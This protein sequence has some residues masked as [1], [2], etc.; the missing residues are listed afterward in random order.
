VKRALLCVSAAFLIAGCSGDDHCDDCGG[1]KPPPPPPLERD[2]PQHTVEYYRLAWQDRDSTRID[3]ALTADYQGTSTDIGVISE[4]I[5]FIKSDEIRA[6]HAMKNDDTLRS[7]S[8]DFGPSSSWTRTSY[9]GDPPDWSVVVVPSSA[10]TLMYANGDVITVSPSN[11]QNLF[12]LKP[13]TVVGT[14]TTWQVIRWQ[15]IHN[16]Q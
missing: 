11:D 1:F 7:V 3:S 14:D 4:T 2:T 9:A 10:I 12:K 16:S 8:V 5:S 6:T 15:E 13:T